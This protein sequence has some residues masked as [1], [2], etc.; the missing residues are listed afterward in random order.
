[1]SDRGLLPAPPPAPRPAAAWAFSWYVERLARGTFASVRWRSATDWRRWDPAVPTL[2]IAN[3][4]NWWDGFLSH[5]VA[6]AMGRDFRILMEKQHLDRYRAFL[7]I[8]ALPMERRSP[9]QAMRDLAVATACL[10]PAG[11][12]WI[13]PQGQRRPAGEAPR[14]LEHGAAWMIR[15]HE[16][17][18]RVVPVA[19]RYPFLSEQRPEAVLLLGEPW[20]L[21]GPREARA[22]ITVRLARMLV[23]TL[24]VLDGDLAVERLDAYDTLVAGRASINNRLDR[25]RHALGLLDEYQPRNG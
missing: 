2:A 23:E 4:T 8:G 22:A 16:G 1:M 25:V 15:H 6:R 12:V 17:P 14:D 7:R 24:V 13:Y 18:L 10:V 11:M 19:F 5:Q 9:M 21:E 3:H 20:L